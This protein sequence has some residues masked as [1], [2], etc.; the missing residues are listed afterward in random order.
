MN[1]PMCETVCP[2]IPS[3]TR[4]IESRHMQESINQNVISACFAPFNAS[5]KTRNKA[6]SRYARWHCMSQ[7]CKKDECEVWSGKTIQ[8]P[9]S[10]TLGL[11]H[12][13]YEGI[14]GASENQWRN[15]A[16]QPVSRNGV[17]INIQRVSASRPQAS[18]ALSL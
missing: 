13:W 2:D 16:D 17:N 10:H 8:R 11:G 7:K 4:K 1:S 18:G 3:C 14:R 15:E 5:M 6:T 12:V 9:S